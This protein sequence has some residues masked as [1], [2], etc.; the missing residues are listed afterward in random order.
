MN[1]RV[2]VSSLALFVA[3]TLLATTASAT[4]ANFK[5]KR[6]FIKGSFQEQGEDKVKEKDK[7]KKVVVDGLDSLKL[8]YNLT[9]EF[10]FDLATEV[11]SDRKRNVVEDA[12]LDEASLS[13]LQLMYGFEGNYTINTLSLEGKRKVNKSFQ[14]SSDW[15]ELKANITYDDGDLSGLTYK[16]KYAFSCDAKGNRQ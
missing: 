7:Y 3:S 1:H 8:T 4:T 5:Y 6:C 14:K 11:K 16:V 12:D 15:F 13:S 9:D 2:L 10:S